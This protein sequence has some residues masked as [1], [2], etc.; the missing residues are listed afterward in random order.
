MRLLTEVFEDVLCHFADALGRRHR[1]FGIDGRDLLIRDTG[2][3][4]HGVDVIDAERQDVVVVDRVDDGVRMKL[5][6]ECLRCSSHVEGFAVSGIDCEDWRAGEAEDMVVLEGLDDLHVHRAE[7]R[8]VA[9]VEDQDDVL[10]VRR[11]VLVLTNEHIELLDG[12]DDDMDI[13][14][15]DLL[16]QNA[17]R[18]IAVCRALLK[19]VVLAHCLVVEVFPVNNEKHLV[20]VV[21][22]GGELCGLEA[23]QCLAGTGCMPD[24]T[25]RRCGAG[26]LIIGRDL[27][28]TEDLLRRGDLVGT[29]DQE[30]ILCGEDAVA[31]QDV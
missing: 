24:V 4:V 26:L 13:G 16:L 17:G 23:G 19:T 1:A 25:A 29:H 8:A 31:R 20:D 2:C 12:G 21:E 27:D 28:A 15:L 10:P 18:G 22:V 30:E 5:I 7:L 9:L 14:I 6:T 11:M 3:H